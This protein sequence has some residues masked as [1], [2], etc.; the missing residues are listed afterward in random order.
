MVRTVTEDDTGLK[1]LYKPSADN[2]STSTPGD[3]ID[4][5]AIH[6]IGAHPDDTWCKNVNTNGEAQPRYVNWLEDTEMLPFVVP[7]ARIMRYGYESQWFGDDTV[8]T[9]RLD[10]SAI[11]EQL[12]EEL[13][14]ERKEFPSRPVI[15]IAHCFGGLVVLKAL[16]MAFDNPQEWRGIFTLT[17]GLIF[18]GTPFRGTEGM[19]Q[20][21]IVEAA[22]SQYRPDQVLGESLRIL[23]PGDKLL[24][25]LVDGFLKTRLNSNAARVACF[26]ET[27]SSNVG[28]I[29]GGQARR[30]FVVNESSGCLDQTDSTEK[31][32]LPRTHFDINKFGKPSE[33]GFRVVRSVVRKMVEAT[34]QLLSARTQAAE[35]VGSLVSRTEPGNRIASAGGVTFNNHGNVQNQVGEQHIAGSLEFH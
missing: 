16:R 7:N 22:L 18:F 35:V 24:Q 6:G 2:Q 19:K 25:D 29:V 33:P 20:N 8:N 30:E 10:P 26:Y 28:A 4:I 5:I 13:N 14:F 34:P 31:H 23:R 17:T 32:S 11:A 9:V 12:L 15:F 27:K 3:T 1:V 21:E